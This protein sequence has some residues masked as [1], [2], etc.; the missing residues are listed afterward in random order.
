MYARVINLRFPPAM[1]A[2]VVDA[3]NGL[4]RTMRNAPGFDGLEVLTNP[5]AGDGL[6]VSFWESEADAEANESSASYIG[7]M[8]KMSSFLYEPVVPIPYEA[9]VRV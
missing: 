7:Q 9:N 1:K 5:L 2:D 8:S 6:I 4:A 3:A